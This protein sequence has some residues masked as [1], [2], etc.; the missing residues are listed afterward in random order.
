MPYHKWLAISV[1]VL[2]LGFLCDAQ[3]GPTHDYIFSVTGV[4][5]AEDGTPLPETE[6]TIEVN[7]PVYEGVTL[8]RTATQTTNPTGG[9][10]FMYTSHK[11]G[12]K[13]KLSVHKEGFEPQTIPGSAPPTGN[14][15]IRL[16]MTRQ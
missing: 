7:G 16:K 12:V 14:H 11:R 13:Y 8:V 2:G 6:V 5:T 4:V 9:F 1:I 3:P 15:T 10:V